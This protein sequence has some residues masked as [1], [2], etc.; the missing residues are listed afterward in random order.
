M[1]AVNLGRGTSSVPRPAGAVESGR[2]EPGRGA[3]GSV[4]VDWTLCDG[5]GL[6]TELLP[7]L[8]ERDEWGFPVAVGQPPASRSDV[9]VPPELVDA[10]RDAVA[11]CPRAALRLRPL[12]LP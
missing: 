11:L 7:E 9:T 1:S 12:P 5:R 8:L 2:S 10:A 4:H 6:C 3:A